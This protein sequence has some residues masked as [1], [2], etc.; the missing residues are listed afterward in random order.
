MAV[1]QRRVDLLRAERTPTP[2]FSVGGLFNNPGGEFTTGW[3][4]GVG[5]GV[6]I[7][8][9]NQGE[10]AESIAATAQLRAER[11]ATRRDVE[12]RVFG[13]IARI[14]AE[15]RQADAYRAASGPDGDR[16]RV[17]VGGKLSRRP[18][19]GPGR[20]RR[21]AE[22]ARSHARG[23]AGARSTCNSRSQIWRRFLAPLSHST[24]VARARVRPGRVRRRAAR[25]P[26]TRRKASS[27]PRCRQ[28]PPRS[29][30]SP[31]ARSSTSW[32]YAASIAAAA[33]EDVKV[34]AL[35]AGRVER[36]DGRRGRRRAAGPGD[37]R[38]RSAP[39]RGPAAA[40][41]GRR[42][43]GEGAGRERAAQ[44]AAQ[45]AALRPR[46][47]RRQGSRRRPEGHGVGAGVARAGERRPRHRRSATSSA[48]RCGRRSP[49]RSSSGW[50]ASASRWTGPAAQPIVEIANLDRVE[51]AA[52]VPAEQLS[53]LKV[54]QNGRQCR[55]TRSR[56]ARS[57]APC[58]PSRRPSTRPRTR[59]SS[60]FGITN[61]ERLLKIGMFAE[62]RVAARA[63]TPTRSSCPPPALVR[64]SAGR[65]STSCPATSPSAPPVTVGLEKPDAI[66]ILSGVQE[67]QTVLTS[68]VY[69]LGEKAKLQEAA[70]RHER[71]PLRRPQ[72]PR[73]SSLASSSSRSPA[74]Y[75]ITTL[76]SGIY[77]EVEFPRI[78][79]RRAV[80][81]SVA[82]HHDDRRHAAARRSRARRAR[83]A[84]RPVEDH[85]RRH[86]ALGHLQSRRRHAVR[87]AAHARQGRRGAPGS[88]CRHPNPA[89]SA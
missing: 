63:S 83:R 59:R 6:P 66:E 67:G 31:A 26:P 89:S 30:R 38:A 68:S 23:A 7:F 84:P 58:W 85:P 76:P 1:E 14:D 88:A 41:G 5:I 37:R 53:R 81:R 73:R 50:S 32:S 15:R 72:R 8:S 69:G 18:H 77:P 19:V 29:A 51:L 24:R 70:S 10:I 27:R 43:A 3:W 17:A 52:N 74:L 65:P 45:P 25:R 12:N 78:A 36:R 21:A 11:E 60:A 64:D 9:R 2:V 54:G 42:G 46:H 57:P 82:A 39:A 79:D 16:S 44:P 75:S 62:A 80:G 20:A 48:P 4:G 28:S 33:N 71:R 22:P 13:A 49:A 35:V 55:P 56:D 86:R 61:G 40:G 34:S 87:A 47:R